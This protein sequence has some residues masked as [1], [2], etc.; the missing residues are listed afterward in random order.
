MYSRR[1]AYITQFTL[2]L[3]IPVL[4]LALHQYTPNPASDIKL[5]LTACYSGFGLL[6]ISWLLLR[7]RP[8]DIIWPPLLTVLLAWVI[9]QVISTFFATY[10]ANSFMVTGRFTALVGLFVLASMIYTT[11]KQF[12]W[13]ALAACTGVAVAA[14]YGLLQKLG[15]DPFPWDEGHLL[16]SEY[17]KLPATFGNPNLAG[18]VLI[19][20][21]IINVYLVLSGGFWRLCI[22]F[23]PLFLLHL[24]F[25]GLRS[26]F[27][28]LAVVLLLVLV[29]FFIQRYEKTPKY[30]VRASLIIF[31]SSIL[32]LVL[33]AL[34]FWK[35][36]TNNWLPLDSSLLLRYNALL[37]GVR[38]WMEHPWL[39]WGPGNYP[40]ENPPF[41]T[42]YEQLWFATEGRV[43]RNV[44][45]DLLEHAV[46][47]GVMGA[48]F[49]IAFF[50]GGIIIGLYT[51]FKAHTK[52]IGLLGGLM[53]C[54]F[55]AF[56]VDGQFGFNLHAPVSAGLFFALT[57]AGMGIL[58]RSLNRSNADVSERRKLPLLTRIS[59][60]LI[61]CAI[62]V[63][64]IYW[65]SRIF[66]GR[67]E[68]Q[69]GR[70]AI[71]WEEY[72]A[73]QE[74]LH[75]AEEAI[76]WSWRIPHELGNVAFAVG[77]L[78]EAARHFERSRINN[79]YDMRNLLKLGQLR[80][81][82]ALLNRERELTIEYQINI[83]QSRLIAELLV[84][85]CPPWTEA[86]LLLAQCT[87]TQAGFSLDGPLET[88]GNPNQLEALQFASKH[89]EIA[90]KE[91][92]PEFRANLLMLHARVCMGLHEYDAAESSLIRAVQANPGGANTLSQYFEYSSEV[93]KVEAFLEELKS[94]QPR[95]EQ[96]LRNN[97]M[98]WDEA[99]LGWNLLY[100]ARALNEIGS[101]EQAAITFKNVSTYL[102]YDVRYWD[103]YTDFALENDQIGAFKESL[104][105]A[106]DDMTIREMTIP[107]GVQALGIF[108]N[109]GIR[110]ISSST[111]RLFELILQDDAHLSLEDRA[112]HYKWAIRMLK[113]TLKE[114]LSEE[115]LQTPWILTRF[116]AFYHGVGLY[117][118]AYNAFH[119][120]MDE[121]PAD[122]QLILGFFWYETCQELHK[123]QEALEIAYAMQRLSPES[124]EWR[125]AEARALVKLGRNEAARFI[126]ETVLHHAP[127]SHEEQLSLQVE[128]EAL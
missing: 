108:W 73:A 121:I 111:N 24:Y 107:G 72:D 5:L 19:V 66:K 58:Y 7:D 69:S 71:E 14:L 114:E 23:L 126:F 100:Q 41:W 75:K 28:A 99:N 96:N 6:L 101:I 94:H 13:L 122:Q 59:V 78:E 3:F 25:T 1:L 37:S 54:L 8:N 45:N 44:H 52:E 125:L 51:Y 42:P 110:G 22:V 95:L 17:A 43:N 10:Q 32:T 84:S 81:A 86:N 20:A 74:L 33:A 62:S 27:V 102:S 112:L 63:N 48:F 70:G 119:G 93:G 88:D 11:P 124:W 106:A 39:G 67:L 57:G 92:R 120:N 97:G 103:V 49:Y 91:A 80:L 34:L 85:L 104:L 105:L 29:V 109:Q 18:H 16:T 90:L 55:L 82:Q 60:A 128:I 115:I 98:P 53:A 35:W 50:T 47:N 30:L 12:R 26:G 9:L 113:A 36:R 61:L 64:L 83:A 40:F 79:A 116:G 117:E 38:M 2:A 123:Y 118:E 89:L 65:E 56:G 68:F 4:I 87:L 77:D 46:N 76:H 127:L 15:L 31:C 21:I